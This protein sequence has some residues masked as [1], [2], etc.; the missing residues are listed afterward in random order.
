[1]ICV[2]FTLPPKMTPT[3][4]YTSWGFAHT[5]ETTTWHDLVFPKH[6][7]LQSDAQNM[8]DQLRLA[9]DLF[10]GGVHDKCLFVAAHILETAA[11]ILSQTHIAF[12][13]EENP[14]GKHSISRDSNKLEET[15]CNAVQQCAT[16]MCVLVRA[17]SVSAQVLLVERKP[18]YAL[19]LFDEYAEIAESVTVP[20]VEDIKG[21]DDDATNGN[22]VLHIENTILK[23]PLESLPNAALLIRAKCALEVY[24]QENP[25]KRPEMTRIFPQDCSR[26]TILFADALLQDA[27]AC[28][29]HVLFAPEKSK[30]KC[31]T[32]L[33]AI[34]C[35]TLDAEGA[36]SVAP[37]LALFVEEI[38]MQFGYIDFGSRFLHVNKEILSKQAPP[39]ALVAAESAIIAAKEKPRV[40]KEKTSGALIPAQSEVLQKLC[41]IR[42]TLLRMLQKLYAAIRSAAGQFATRERLTGLV[43]RA[44]EMYGTVKQAMCI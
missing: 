11:R 8:I 3:E 16:A 36:L 6:A 40:E 14:S 22:S 21:G 26:G 7:I 17:V 24:H 34:I 30:Q 37:L 4:R 31:Q 43:E 42:D 35:H 39:E 9:E 44:L 28:C 25:G 20:L 1:M 27:V 32:S 41:T 19:A 33:A 5:A 12:I 38:C 13:C 29:F 15:C 10:V 2:S 18:K 23:N